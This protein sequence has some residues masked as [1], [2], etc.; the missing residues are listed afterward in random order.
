MQNW[1]VSPVSA[2]SRR[3][4]SWPSRSS[5]VR[6]EIVVGVEVDRAAEIHLGTGARIFEDVGGE[7]EV[8]DLVDR[9]ARRLEPLGDLADRDRFSDRV[10]QLEDL[11]RAVEAARRGRA[12]CAAAPSAAGVRCDAR[13]DAPPVV[14]AALSSLPLPRRAVPYLASPIRYSG[15]HVRYIG[16]SQQEGD[17]MKRTLTDCA[18]AVIGVAVA[19]DR[20][21]G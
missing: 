9:R 18:F 11:D 6:R 19:G 8:D 3:T 15:H 5:G 16:Q 14:S 21:V 20:R 10:Q 7:E 12:V 13:P 17:S 1:H 2:A 4:S